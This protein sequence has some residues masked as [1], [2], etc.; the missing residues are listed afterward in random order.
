MQFN[1]DKVIEVLQ[2]LPSEEPCVDYK[3]VPYTK[4]QNH[5]F[6]KDVIAMLNSE[7]GVG[8]DKF[9]II[10]VENQ[11]RKRI[12]IQRK[13]WRD[14]NEWQ[15][16]LDKIIPRPDVSTGCVEYEGNWFGYILISGTNNEW[17]YEAAESV[18]S[19]KDDK[20]TEKNIIAK[21]Q[22]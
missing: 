14:D 13:L 17:V 20:V 12:G 8:K 21:G 1:D 7:A 11:T 5:D 4:N 9:I 22:A 2:R 18:I 10:G 6:L 15:N 19:S 16:L 3:I